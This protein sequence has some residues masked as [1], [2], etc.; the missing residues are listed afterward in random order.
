MNN[1]TTCALCFYGNT[2]GNCGPG[3]EVGIASGYGLDGTGI[4]SRWWRDFTHLPRPALGPTETPVQ[5]VPCL[6]QG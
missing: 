2:H 1:K 6:F 3:S 5:W 4:E